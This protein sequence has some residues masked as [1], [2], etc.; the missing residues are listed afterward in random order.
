M[1]FIC[2]GTNILGW[3]RVSSG[4]HLGSDVQMEQDARHCLCGFDSSF[5]RVHPTTTGLVLPK[6][7]T[8]GG[9]D[10]FS[11]GRS[12]RVGDFSQGQRLTQS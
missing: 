2:I 7:N 9:L 5:L 4:N 12:D 11:F 10:L 6:E 3:D 1:G 8:P